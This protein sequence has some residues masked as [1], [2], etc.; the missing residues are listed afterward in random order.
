M[1]EK[2]RPFWFQNDADQGKYDI[3]P[4]EAGDCPGK[5]VIAR[6]IHGR[7]DHLRTRYRTDRVGEHEGGV[8]G[9]K[10]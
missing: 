5:S 3:K 8:G 4:E 9:R 10:V 1:I 7:P 2:S 6:H